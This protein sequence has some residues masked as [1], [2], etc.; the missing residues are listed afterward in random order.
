MA[1]VAN[2]VQQTPG[3]G[4]EGGMSLWVA[5]SSGRGGAGVQLPRSALWPCQALCS[6]TEV[7]TW[8]THSRPAAGGWRGSSDDSTPLCLATPSRFNKE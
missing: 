1:C 8:E 3:T 6:L 4:R 2:T 5:L 7:Q